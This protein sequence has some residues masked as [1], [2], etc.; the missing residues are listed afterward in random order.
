MK[1]TVTIALSLFA[2]FLVSDV[3]AN[4]KDKPGDKQ[5]VDQQRQKEDIA[6]ESSEDETTSGGI[7]IDRTSVAEAQVDSLNYSENAFQKFNFIFYFLYK[8][9]Y[10]KDPRYSNGLAPLGLETN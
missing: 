10:D 4:N 2:F 7:G 5:Q 6:P 3:I 9:K 8:Y 1:K